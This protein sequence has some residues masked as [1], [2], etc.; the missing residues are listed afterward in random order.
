MA[1]DSQKLMTTSFSPTSFPHPSPLPPNS[2]PDGL[3]P[4]A[5]PLRFISPLPQNNDPDGLEADGRKWGIVACARGTGGYATARREA[6]TCSE[7]NA[8][9][10]DSAAS[11]ATSSSTSYSS[12]PFSNNPCLACVETPCCKRLPLERIKVK[13]RADLETLQMYLRHRW[14]EVG[15][16][17]DGT[18]MLFYQRPCRNLD[19]HTGL[20]VVHGTP[21]Q[22]WT[23]KEYP[24]YRC[25][26]QRV[27]RTEQSL[28]FIR[29]DARRVEVLMIM[30]SYDVDTGEIA[31]VPSWEE[32]IDTFASMPL[33]D[34]DRRA[35]GGKRKELRFPVPPP[36]KERH[37]ELFRFRQQFPGVR[38]F[39][40]KKEWVTVVETYEA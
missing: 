35:P 18:W 5:G 28:E 15:L 8:C 3:P 19:I 1:G 12:E 40:G 29:F 23:C 10:R 17:D 32:M 37:I 38:I 27:F 20:C 13:T 22:P 11:S 6:K 16:K 26:Y 2:D 39:K 9:E 21:E 33:D 14:F 4:H 34:P 30:V 7:A 36:Q 24:S 25:W 31:D